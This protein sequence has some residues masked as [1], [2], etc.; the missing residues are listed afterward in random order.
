MTGTK[1][2]AGAHVVREL[3]ALT[4]GAGAGG[5]T[6]AARGGGPAAALAAARPARTAAARI[7][8]AGG[9]DEQVAGGLRA[10]VAER[11]GGSA[12]R[13]LRVHDALAEYPGSVPELL[14]DEAPPVPPAPS[15]GALRAPAPRSVHDTFAL[16]IEHAAPEHAAVAL[17]ALPDRTVELLLSGGALPGPGLTA[18]V[19]EHGG[20]RARV[21][22]AR[23]SRLDPRV[24]ARLLGVGD[25]AVGAAVY[26]NPRATYSLRRTLARRL[27]TVPMDEALRAELTDPGAD[28]PRTWLAPLL[29]SGDPALTARALGAGARGVAQQY[30]LARVWARGGPEALRGLLDDPAVTGHLTRPVHGAVAAA[31]A[32]EDGSGDA[33]RRLYARGE[34]YDDP[35]RLPGLLAVTRGTSTLRDLLAEPYAHDLHA[36]HKAHVERPF[37][38]KAC[39]ELARHEGASDEQ[40]LAFRLS[41]LNE[42][43]RTGGRRSGNISPPERRLAEEELDY[44]AELWAEGVVAA[45]LLDPVELVRAARPA[46]RALAALSALEGRGLL[47]G[48]AVGELRAAAEAH[49]GDSAEAWAAFDRLLPEYPGGLRELIAAAA[50]AVAAEGPQGSE[51][52]GESGA[53]GASAEAS[54]GDDALAAGGSGV[55]GERYDPP[56]KPRGAVERA[57]LSALDLLRTLAP[58]D[59]APPD[60]VDVGVLRFLAGTSWAD[61]PGL[62]TPGWLAGACAAREVEPPDH[63]SWYAAP[64]SATVRGKLPESWGS[65]A[66]LTELAYTQGI[67]T[68]DDLLGWLPAYRLLSLPH[69]WR[70]SAFPVGWRNALARRLRSELGADPEGWLRLAA[71]AGQAAV[72]DTWLELLSRARAGAGPGAEAEVGPEDG[73]GRPSWDRH[74]ARPGTPEEALGLLA[75]G[76]HLWVW[77]VGTLLCLADAEVID[78]VL[79]R[80]GPD[81]PW[82]LAAY[83]LRHDHIPRPAFE[84][85]LAGRDP[86]AL[87]VLATQQRWLEDGLAARLA[88][89]DDP[90][91]DLALLRHTRDPLVVRR[92]VERSS[93]RTAAAAA[94]Q[95]AAGAARTDASTDAGTDAAT[96][97]GTG[98]PMEPVAALVLAEVRADPSAGPAGGMRWLGSA[99]PDL[100]EEIL[101]RYA[102]ELGF[103]QQVFGC[104]SLLEHGGATRLTALVG[105]GPLGQA[106]TKLCVKALDS[107]D[108][109]A[110]LR[111]R[112]DRERAPAKMVKKLRRASHRW[113]ATSAV[114]ADPVGADWQALEAAHQEE[115]LPYWE[116]L[117]GMSLAPPELRLRY[118]GSVREPG[119]SG[120][121]DGAALTRARARHGVAGLYHCATVTQLDGLLTSGLLTAT[122]L[123]DVAAPAALVLDYLG[124][125]A[126][127]TDA[128]SEAAAALAA[129]AR[130]VRVR[131]GSDEAAWARVTARLTGRDPRWEPVSPVDALLS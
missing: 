69:D 96:A 4:M 91:T 38:P 40:R 13:W 92:V 52:S 81:G 9:V 108:P 35:G 129:L 25:P 121:P 78:A 122:D 71:V 97:T 82:L 31:L 26:R 125:A 104:L 109:A 106:A 22:L 117:I 61:S 113:T 53:A 128:P 29:C 34:P 23:H 36:L 102:T 19:T 42:P 50:E 111:A 39:E 88:D 16:L 65:S 14:A 49:L 70:R 64:A 18:A 79:S 98:A 103:V 101:V 55:A 60:P 56:L 27:D 126:R 85:L 57:A 41:V 37:M 72:E 28:V 110:V 123:L 116:E 54:A 95:A 80:L 83:L 99:E 73:A 120:L 66:V 67:L 119:P 89:V 11:L 7:T 12:A 6:G 5:G 33:L 94:A 24:L 68:A 1:S 8:A 127:R 17:A 15:G 30:A 93:R 115:P 43:W 112:L 2:G 100:V 131:L 51:E 63:G 87:R 86:R 46:V 44:G 62:A 74:T 107:R 105:R 20:T 75:H 124:S 47:T 77:P 3:I 21:A 130:L 118:A 59:A 84:R 45:G 90:G 58:A 114:T 32:E 10:L 76:D 48:A